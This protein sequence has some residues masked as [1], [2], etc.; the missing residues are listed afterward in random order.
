MTKMQI[1]WNKISAELTELKEEC[2]KYLT[3]LLSKPEYKDGISCEPDCGTSVC[4]TY[5]GG[6]HPERYANPFSTVKG[7]YMKNGNIYLDTE[8]CDEYHIDR[9]CDIIELY[10]VCEFIEDYCLEK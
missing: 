2:V 3:D 1:M 6:N 7:V 9:I 10:G 4:V 8:D 5:D